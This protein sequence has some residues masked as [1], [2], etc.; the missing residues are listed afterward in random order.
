M[1]I[2]LLTDI[3]EDVRNLEQALSRL[4]NEKCETIICLGDIV[5]FTSSFY[6]YSATKNAEECIRLVRENCSV[7][8]AGNHDLH[9]I[10]KI[11][12]HK[13]G[14]KYDEN[15]YNLDYKIRAKK[16]KN[17]IWL[18]DDHEIK[19]QLSDSAIE[20][21]YHLNETETRVLGNLSFFFSHFC[22][23]DFSGSAVY[24]PQEPSHLK[25]H[26][27]YM[28]ANQC[29][30]SIS[31]HGHPEGIMIVNKNEFLLSDFEI[32]TLSNGPQWMVIPCV[33]RTNRVNGVMALDTSSGEYKVIAINS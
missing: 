30:I 5:G 29:T 19:C 32:R 15:W 14:F 20:Y 26:F 22:C 10:Q 8:V 1:K 2:G 18:Y 17:Q 16:G 7:V 27:E 6:N 11:P 23:P 31:G 13:A 21:I 33:A 24:F 3:H 28:A 12:H 9:A 25:K 4:S